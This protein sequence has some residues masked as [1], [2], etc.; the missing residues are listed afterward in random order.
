MPDPHE[1]V[2]ALLTRVSAGNRDAWNKLLLV[3]YKELHALAHGAMSKR[4]PGRTLQTTA[5]VHE[6][7]I[8]LVKDKNERWKNRAHFFGVASRAMRNILVDKYRSMMAAKRGLGRQPVS[9]NNVIGRGQELAAADNPFKDWEALD[10]A[11]TKLG[12]EAC[13]KRKCTIVELRF[14]VGL[15]HKEAAEVLGVSPATVK[16]DWEFT[17]TWLCREMRKTGFDEYGAEQQ[18]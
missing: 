7:Y 16:R 9:L 13:H 18:G 11:L 1:D 4:R 5:L 17:R 15:T 8:R 3:V 2:T 12:S 6:A 14:F 10:R